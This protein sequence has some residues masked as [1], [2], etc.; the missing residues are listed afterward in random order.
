MTTTMSPTP[1]PEEDPFEQ[2][3]R[4]IDWIEQLENVRVRHQSISASREVVRYVDA[5]RETIIRL[6]G[7]QTHEDLR[8][9]HGSEVADL[10][11]IVRRR[12]PDDS[13]NGQIKPALLR[14]G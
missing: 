10:V 2:V 3:E 14:E 9:I 5:L 6:A 7:R 1:E 4:Q 13:W 11:D 8:L 12:D